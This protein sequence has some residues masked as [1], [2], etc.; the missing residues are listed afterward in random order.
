MIKAIRFNRG[1]WMAYSKGAYTGKL[2]ET[3]SYKEFRRFCKDHGLE[4]P[5]RDKVA[6]MKCE[7]HYYELGGWRKL[8]VR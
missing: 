7:G 5:N 4:L 2:I 3:K 1:V 6:E 8:F